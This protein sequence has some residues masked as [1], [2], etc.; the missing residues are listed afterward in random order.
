MG[1]KIG[2]FEKAKVKVALNRNGEVFTFR[3][4]KE[5]EFGEK[6]KEFDENVNITL[7][8]I[9]HEQAG[10]V[11]K[12]V[13]DETITRS[14]KQPMILCLLE[15]TKELKSKDILV[16]RDIEYELVKITDV[17]NLGVIA[18]ISLEVVDNGND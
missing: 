5:N 14:K 15:D 3:R 2:E 17:Q 18:D 13:S 1:L 11:Q 6:S 8:G 10:Y 16:I 12:V 4:M 7:K 9:Y